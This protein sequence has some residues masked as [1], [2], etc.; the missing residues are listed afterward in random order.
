MIYGEAVQV[1]IY[2]RLAQVLVAGTIVSASFSSVYAAQQPTNLSKEILSYPRVSDRLFATNRTTEDSISVSSARIETINDKARFV[3]YVSSP[4]EITGVTIDGTTATCR[5]LSSSRTSGEYYIDAKSGSSYNIRVYYRYGNNQ[6]GIADKKAYV[7]YNSSKKPTVDLSQT[8]SGSTCYLVIKIS[9]SNPIVKVKVNNDTISFS[10]S[11]GT[12]K[13]KVTKSG[14]YK[15]E[16]TDIAGNTTTEKYEVDV[17]NERPT[18]KLDKKYQNGKW[19]LVIKATPNGNAEIEKVTVDGSKVSC[20]KAGDTIE[21]LISSTGTYKVVVKDNYDHETSDSL[22][23][24]VNGTTNVNQPSLSL[25]QNNVGNMAYLVISASPSKNVSN[26]SLAKVTVNGNVVA[27]SGAGGTLQYAVS[28]TGNYTVVATDVYGNQTTQN[29]YVTLPGS[30]VVPNYT[31]AASTGSSNV[32]F[33]LNKKTWSKNGAAQTMDAAPIA[34]YG[35]IYIPIRY[36]AYALNINPSKVTW[37]KNTRAAVIYDGSNVIRVPLGSKVMTVN[38][39]SQ[40]MEAAAISQGGRIYIPIS[41]VAKAF[42]G[43]QMNWNNSAKQITIR[44]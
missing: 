37:D 3:V 32:T 23:I 14:T 24:D 35:R 44:R 2:K 11:G 18:L 13:Y 40:T 39:V 30:R 16:V 15:V 7:S 21:Y 34:K 22:Y 12:E 36:V 33:T 4:V 25:S 38:G 5:N 41:Q 42:T 27:L 10:S 1:K 9:D 6:A 26:N 43:V 20:R 31:P 19:Y 29:L 17:D 28:A 8:F